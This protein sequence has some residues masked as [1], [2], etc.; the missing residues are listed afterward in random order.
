MSQIFWFI[1]L[2]LLL[3]G[4]GSA[5]FW[6]PDDW[7]REGLYALSMVFL[8]AA[9]LTQNDTSWWVR[10]ICTVLAVGML[11]WSASGVWLDLKEEKNA[12]KEVGEGQGDR[13]VPEGAR[14]EEDH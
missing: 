3:A 12:R 9:V 6:H 8:L 2:G 11:V 14:G 7:R 10:S 1:S 4:L 13:E 5:F